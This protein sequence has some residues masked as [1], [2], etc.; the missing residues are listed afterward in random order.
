M[1][2]KEFK[3]A[4]YLLATEGIA[5]MR[6][7]YLDDHDYG[8]TLLREVEEICRGIDQPPYT[9][10]LTVDECPAVP[11]YTAWASRYD[12]DNDDNPLISLEATV[13]DAMLSSCDNGRALDAACGTGR[14][15]ARLASLG[16]EVVGVDATHA[17][18]DVARRN[19]PG[20]QYVQGDLRSLPAADAEF[21]LVLCT[22][23][24][25]HV[26]ELDQVIAE[27]ARV[28]RPGGQVVIVDVHPVQVLL[29]SHVPVT[30]Q[31]AVAAVRNN[32]HLTSR[33]LAAFD[34][35]GLKVERCEEPVFTAAEA[36]KLPA[37]DYIGEANRIAFAGTPALLAWK[38]RKTAA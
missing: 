33:Y 26:A 15:E 30:T 2:A 28:T 31:A 8:T 24:L 29:G 27:F 19:H 18:L 14:Q 38:L 9:D 36:A 7:W 10:V 34:A 23:A 32:M 12:A 6:T 5:L 20:T 13:L 22:L 17:M 4:H 25:T 11:G 21:N 3:L 37:A 35:C 16:Y 1:T